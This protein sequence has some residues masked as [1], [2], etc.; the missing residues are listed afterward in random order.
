VFE[1]PIGRTDDAGCR[2]RHAAIFQFEVPA[3]SFKAGLYHRARFFHIVD[4]V[5]SRLRV[6]EAGRCT[7]GKCDFVL[8]D[9]TDCRVCRIAGLQDCRTERQKGDSLDPSAIAAIL[10]FCNSAISSA[11]L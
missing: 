5:M 8:Q 11:Q 1:T 4:E 7:S 6:P 2:D 10:Q 9:C 3:G